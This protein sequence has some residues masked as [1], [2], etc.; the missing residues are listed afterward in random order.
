MRP[1]L[2]LLLLVM[3]APAL[4]QNADVKV[5]SHRIVPWTLRFPDGKKTRPAQM[6]LFDL[7]NTGTKPIYRIRVGVT[8]LDNKGKRLETEQVGFV[9]CDKAK[10]ML[11]GQMFRG[12]QKR[13][14]GLIVAPRNGKANRVDVRILKVDHKKPE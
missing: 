10:P 12:D 8:P 6:V 7:K 1:F 13:G 9:I 3:A 11:P 4:A 2:L 5:L 14:T